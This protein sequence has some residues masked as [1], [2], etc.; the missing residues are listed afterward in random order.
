MR[1]LL[2]LSLALCALV[3]CNESDPEALYIDVLYQLRCLDC[4][5][6]TN[7][8]PTRDIHHLDGDEGFELGCELSAAKDGTLISFYAEYV[9]PEND[10]NDF[11]I[12]VN[13]AGIGETDPGASCTVKVLD[14]GT[15][16]EGNCV[17]TEDEPEPPCDVAL[18]K[19]GGIIRGTLTCDRIPVQ[20][21]LE[22]F[23]YLYRPSTSK[24]V[25]V[26]IRGCSGE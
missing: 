15:T 4:E 18:K 11:S 26:E 17:G 23:R 10:A 5:P 24:A 12:E 22:P 8:G 14:N 25:P 13:Q 2:T 1:R 20:D 21:M 6:R 19:E 3:G 16:Y 7:D 9:D